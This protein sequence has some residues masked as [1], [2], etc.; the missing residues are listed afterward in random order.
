M[1]ANTIIDEDLSPL[2]STAVRRLE[3]WPAANEYMTRLISAPPPP[4][5]PPSPPPS[6]SIAVRRLESWPAAD[7]YIRMQEVNASG[8]SR[9]TMSRGRS[10][11]NSKML[12]CIA[13]NYGSL[14]T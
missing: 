7:I 8:E 5:P 2:S 11:S 6:S 9:S 4:L 1:T 13:F 10:L 3:N 12:F 14:K